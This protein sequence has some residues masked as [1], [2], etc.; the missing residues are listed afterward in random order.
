MC[1]GE[2]RRMSEETSLLW[3]EKLILTVSTYSYEMKTPPGSNNTLY[4]QLMNCVGFHYDRSWGQINRKQF[5]WVNG[6]SSV[7][8]SNRLTNQQAHSRAQA[9]GFFQL[10]WPRLINWLC[11]SMETALIP[12]VNQLAWKSI[13]WW[14]AYKENLQRHVLM[15]TNN[16]QCE[17]QMP[18]IAASP[19]T[20]FKNE[21][22]IFTEHFY[23]HT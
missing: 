1:L 20:D 21:K 13:P 15:P 23:N 10:K 5:P 4:S 22:W 7:P 3:R 2:N 6:L 19:Q 16:N 9:R 8:Y 17:G 11:V 18:R 14:F 12:W